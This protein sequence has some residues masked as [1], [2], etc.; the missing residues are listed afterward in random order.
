M[1]TFIKLFIY[2]IF[3]ILFDLVIAFFVM[4]CWNSVIPN[5]GIAAPITYFQAFLL[6][7]LCSFLF[8]FRLELNRDNS[9]ENKQSIN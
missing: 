1:E 2:Y 6:K 7:L 3:A 5:V 9:K 8:K 4:L